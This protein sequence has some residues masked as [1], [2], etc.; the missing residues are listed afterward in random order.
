MSNKLTQYE[1]EALLQVVSTQRT[2]DSSSVL[3]TGATRKLWAMLRDARVT[4][5]PGAATLGR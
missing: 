4:Q 5:G 1:I 2:L 3:L